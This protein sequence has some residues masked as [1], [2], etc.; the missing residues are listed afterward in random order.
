MTKDNLQ[1]IKQKLQED[2]LVIG[3]D[4]V[5][6]KLNQGLIE[7]VFLSANCPPAVKN[8]FKHYTSMVDV[9]LVILEIDNE[10]L[11]VFCKKNFFVSVL[12][13]LVEK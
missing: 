2:K 4:S 3:R 11:G 9:P 7:T 12:G 8:D 6:K 10:E 5:S 13:I 1:L